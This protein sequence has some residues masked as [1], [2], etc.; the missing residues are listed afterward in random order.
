M[1]STQQNSASLPGSMATAS[2]AVPETEPGTMEQLQGFFEKYANHQG[3]SSK[4][5]L[6]GRYFWKVLASYPGLVESEMYIRINQSAPVR[7]PAVLANYNLDNTDLNTKKFDRQAAGSADLTP[8]TMY[9]T[10]DGNDLSKTKEAN[11]R[12]RLIK[13]LIDISDDPDAVRGTIHSNLIIIDTKSKCVKRFEPLFDPRYTFPID[14]ELK[15]FFAQNLPKYRYHMCDYHPQ[16]AVSQV[17]PS[18]GM[19]AAFVLKKAMCVITGQRVRKF[20]SRTTDDMDQEEDKIL[21]FADAIET[22]YGPLPG[23]PTLEAGISLGF[24]L[25]IDGYGGYGVPYGPYGYAGCVDP[26]YCPGVYGYGSDIVIGGRGFGRGYGYGGGRGF[27][28][29]GRG[30]GG[31]GSHGFGG[32]GRGGGSHGGGREHGWGDHRDERWRHDGWEHRREWGL[33]GTGAAIGAGAGLLLGGGIGGLL[34]G[35][36]AGGLSG[37]LIGR[38]DRGHRYYRY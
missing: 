16:K 38:R 5:F 13:L 18:Q 25:P 29:G 24:N 6:D 26:F 3:R 23:N 22:E 21:R 19:C 12:Y 2:Q 34:I 9:L 10:F 20:R 32:G 36:A 37:Y 8:F 4:C 28:G 7:D 15:S 11:V 31:G 27:G 33:T 35:G 30:F 14:Q 17:C 1:S